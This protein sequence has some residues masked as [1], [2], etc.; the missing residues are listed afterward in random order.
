[1]TPVNGNLA[2]IYLYDNDGTTLLNSSYSGTTFDQYTDGL[3][4]G[5]YY[6]RVNCY[7]TYKFTTY[8]FSDTLITPAQAND[9]EPNDSKA[10][11]LTLNP[12]NKTTGH[13]GYY[14]NNKR[15]TADWYKITTTQDGQLKLSLTPVN[16]NLAWIYLYDNDGTTLLNSSYSGA[17]FDQYT[18]GLAAGTYYVKVNCYYNYKFA[19]YTFSDTLITPAQA[20]DS[21]PN[22]SKA[23]AVTLNPNNKTTGH[24]G[25]YNNNKRDTTDWYKITTTQDGQLKLSLT[26]VNGNLAWIYLYDNDGTTLLNSS[27]SG[28]TFDQYTDGLAAGTYYVRVNCYYTYKFTTYTFSDTLYTYTNVT[29]EEPNGKPYQAKT[30]ASNGTATGHTGFYYNVARDSADWWKI[31][32]TGSGAMTVNLNLE[33][34][35]C[36]GNQYTWMYIYKDTNAAPI[37]S[38][39]SNANFSANLSSL[40]QGYYWVK[41]NTYYNY[42]F[43]SYNLNPVFT[44]VT[45][46]S[47]KLVTADTAAACSNTST[48]S[49]KCSKSQPPYT[50]QLYRYGVAYGSAKI[51]TNN[52]TFQFTNLPQGAYYVTAYGDG[53]TGTTFGK[54]PNISVMPAVTGTL[55]T[56]N[57]TQTSAKTNWTTIT[58]AKFYIVQYHKAGDSAWLTK[59]S[60]GNIGI[61]TLNG[62]TANTTYT[63]R[64]QAADSVGNIVATSKFTDSVSFTTATLFVAG[65]SD[66][67]S[68]SINNKQTSS[69]I[70]YPNP[71][72]TQFRM[73]VNAAFNNQTLNA[74]LRDMN[75]N[76]V[77]TMQNVNAATLNN[78]IV[79][80]SKLAN[81]LY[82]LIITSND[83]KLSA[84]QKIVVAK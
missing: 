70:V 34:N 61:V 72:N 8:T 16:G 15:D 80:V 37:Y 24:I 75:G 64:V 22:D 2:W 51:I 26:P 27:Y 10:Q 36:C 78:K 68:M 84:M 47:I 57:I 28:T 77:W 53:A 60:A 46:A 65:A 58:C 48:L 74:T 49:F 12:N 19:P 32:Y 21:E 39:Y 31:N 50:V 41:V 18:D 9:G 33:A 25:Y 42:K 71:V 66:E 14:Y 29:D 56:T 62:L 6:V 13:V 1:L 82:S 4:A 69:L 83:N 43:Q 23:Q 20:N 5:T 40:T 7:Y 54:S 35:K 17:A 67:E 76:I 38:N 45:K 52:K 73:Q 55:S 11:A 81:G 3:A 30:I 79:D 63:W 59:N 44:Q